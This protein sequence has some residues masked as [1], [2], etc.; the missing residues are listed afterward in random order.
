MSLDVHLRDGVVLPGPVINA[1][2]LAALLEEFGTTS[3]P[4][5]Q[6]DLTFPSTLGVPGARHAVAQ[7]STT[8]LSSGVRPGLLLLSDRAISAERAALP[9]M[10]AT[11]AVWKTMVRQG[12]WD[13]PLIVESAQ[14]FDTHHVALLVASGASAVLPSLA[15]QFAEAPEVLA[16]EPN[17]VEAVSYT[18]LAW[19]H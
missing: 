10:L 19:N 1:A 3:G 7:L 14:V 15:L 5:V 8:P 17:A 2:E 11:A 9:A 4:V 18:H 6:I 12:W 16:H 13:V